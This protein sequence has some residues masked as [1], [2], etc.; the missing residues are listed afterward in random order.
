MSIQSNPDFFDIPSPGQEKP[1]TVDSSKEQSFF[2]VPSPE[3]TWVKPEVPSILEQLKTSP[4]LFQ[5]EAA[6]ALYSLPSTTAETY[7]HLAKKGQK[8]GEEQAAKRGKIQSEES[9]QFTEKAVNFV[10]DVI[11]KLG[12]K[13]PKIF[14]TH[15][16]AAERIGKGIEEKGNVVLPKEGR[17]FIEKGSIGAG[18]AVPILLTRASPLIKGAAIGTAAATEASDLSEG[19]KLAGNLSIPALISIIHSIVTKKYHPPKGEATHLYNEGKRLGMTDKQLAPIL[20]T[21]GQIERHGVLASGTRGTKKAFEQTGEVLGNVIEDMQNRPANTRPY[22]SRQ[23]A[24]LLS[25]L[26][27]QRNKIEGRTHSL[28]TQEKSAVDFIDNAISDIQQ[29]GAT[30]KQVVGTWRSINRSGANNRD[31]QSVKDSLLKSISATDKQLAE[32][33]V[34]T[35]KLYSQYISNVKEINPSQFNAF[36]DAGELQ[37]LLAAVFTGK[38]ETL[39]KQILNMASLGTLRKISSSILTDPTAQSL[40]RN[41]GKAVRD[42]RKASA[43][44]TGNQLKEYVR[45]NLPKEYDEVDW[46][47]LGIKD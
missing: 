27:S 12:E 33:L 14:P 16:Q 1:S 22:S 18:R 30:N 47:A 45:K 26:T 31:I 36:V 5:R 3:N 43:L 41:F 44:A 35:N 15:E 6:A 42:G 37:D 7:R 29:N 23:Q 25:D 13:F 8:L 19:G 2:D 40:V 11:K 39:A 4:Y 38:P 46:E 32:D 17:G 10:P 34:A 21:E 24:N 9:K 28:S 20:A